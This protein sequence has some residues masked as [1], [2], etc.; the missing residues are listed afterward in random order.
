M[1]EYEKTV[2]DLVEQLVAAR[3]E[4]NRLRRDEEVD[5]KLGPPATPQQLAELERLLGK[6]LPPSYRA[7]MALHNG[8]DEFQGDF[9]LLSVEDRQSAM[10]KA[11][12][13]EMGAFFPEQELENP[14]ATWGF[15]VALGQ[16]S[17]RLTFLDTR[18]VDADGEMEVAAFEYTEEEARFASFAE[19]LKDDLKLQLDIIEHE[20]EGD[21][22]TDS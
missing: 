19:F 13:E 21:S 3:K 16:T 2:K 10:V 15:L 5:E 11:R 1:T 4:K 8:W 17:G 9:Q 22:D 7:F 18:A 20:R 14:F 6:S 12:S